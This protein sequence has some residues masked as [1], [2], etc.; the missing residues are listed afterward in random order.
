VPLHDIAKPSRRGGRKGLTL[1]YQKPHS[2]I[3]ATPA[4][5]REQSS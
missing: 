2:R 4:G 3:P 1:K 5:V